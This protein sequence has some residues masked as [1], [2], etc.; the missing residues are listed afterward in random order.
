MRIKLT[1]SAILFLVVVVVAS[2]VYATAPT[3]DD[4]LPSIELF[5]SFPGI[6]PDD[7]GWEFDT[8]ALDLDDYIMDV[9]T[10]PGSITWGIGAGSTSSFYDGQSAS[11]ISATADGAA[12]LPSVETGNSVDVYGLQYTG[13]L[14]LD[15]RAADDAVTVHAERYVHYSSFRVRGPRVG[16]DNRVG[17]SV[18]QLPF[19]WV[20]A[21]D[22]MTSGIGLLDSSNYDDILT[23]TGSVSGSPIV[24]GGAQPDYDYMVKY[25]DGSSA[26]VSSTLT[27]DIDAN[28]EFHIIPVL[29]GSGLPTQSRPVF[30]SFIAS[31]EDGSTDWSGGTILL[32]PAL[33]P[34]SSLTIAEFC[35]FEGFSSGAVPSNFPGDD[36]GWSRVGPS[37]TLGVAEITDTGIP[38]ASWPGAVDGN[39]V[40][41]L[42]LANDTTNGIEK[43]RIISL[44]ISPIEP[45]AT[46]GLSMNIA[47]TSTDSSHNPRVFLRAKGVPA[48]DNTTGTKLSKSALPTASDGWKQ[49]FTTYTAPLLTA[50]TP[51]SDGTGSYN[52]H[53]QGVQLFLQFAAVQTTPASGVDM[54]VDNVYFYKLSDG[55][56]SAIDEEGLSGADLGVGNIAM[57]LSLLA[58]AS[59]TPTPVLGD[60]EAASLALAGWEFTEDVGDTT[61]STSAITLQPNVSKIADGTTRATG[62]FTL[63]TSVNH[64]PLSS[65]SNCGNL[66]LVGAD[67]RTSGSDAIN[68]GIR[69]SLRGVYDNGAVPESAVYSFRCFLQTDASIMA[70][71][72]VM[73]LGMT[74][75]G[76]GQFD[77]LATGVVQGAGMPF[78]SSRNINATSP[79]WRRMNITS[80]FNNLT[81]NPLQPLAVYFQ[82]VARTKSDGSGGFEPQVP[83]A[84]YSSDPIMGT[85]AGYDTAE[86]VAPYNGHAAVYIDDVSVVSVDTTR[87]YYDGD[88]MY[89]PDHP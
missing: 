7:E 50:N 22:A 2:Q 89:D 85:A 61:Y 60:F 1:L 8:D 80:S 41:H 48:G 82:A 17:T 55:A 88:L 86:E 65:A 34:D 58:N 10:A 37:S 12:T 51:G 57:D 3:I 19:T 20:I 73:T 63:V 33:T 26:N 36:Y 32:T 24:S 54:Y 59:A 4:H 23:F 75:V 67:S 18:T 9:D 72:P 5:Q 79:V 74:N 76:V 13:A 44:P 70:D 46:Y 16:A 40:L 77:A 30:V 53:Y 15:Y 81:T 84:V 6:T 68:Y 56:A 35:S 64:T 87:N 11:D 14:S 27:I 78:G 47:T 62:E 43:A 52:F 42:D 49:L 39:N 29:D 83:D 45:G 21:G 38:A 31:I 66:Q 25:L 69:Y 28:G 71:T